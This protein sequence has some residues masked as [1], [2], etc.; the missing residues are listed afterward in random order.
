MR[1]ILILGGMHGNELLGVRLVRSLQRTPIAGVDVMIANPRA[2]AANV[3]FTESDLN[4]SFGK[5]KGET[6]EVRRAKKIQQKAAQYD[7]VLDFHNTQTPGNNCSFVG[8]ACN[9]LLY[10]VA[11]TLGFTACIEATYDCV[12]KYCPNTIS[13]EVSIGDILDDVAVWRQKI[14]DARDVP[15]P[16]TSKPLVLY[17]FQRRVTW[18]EKKK[19]VLDA[20]R[21]FVAISN[22]DK[23]RLKV[24]GD[25]VPIFVGSR[26]TEYYATLLSKER[27]V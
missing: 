24:T 2:V 18:A 25:C 4:R 3:R 10:D 19:Y 7:I 1:K 27:T 9:P 16:A 22:K 21:P 14:A 23:I 12:N 15:S 6:Y 20:W 11:K 13:M 8:D 17:R 5:Q 26:L